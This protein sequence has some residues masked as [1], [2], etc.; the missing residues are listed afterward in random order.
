MSKIIDSSKEF[1]QLNPRLEGLRSTILKELGD[2]ARFKKDYDKAE[3]LYKE[4]LT[5]GDHPWTRFELGNIQM[6]RGYFANG[7]K[8]IFLAL[9][10]RP[11]L[12]LVNR[13]VQKC[14][15]KGYGRARL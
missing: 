11:T 8:N 9:D 12:W 14:N 15:A 1:W 6:N 4:S 2:Q 7:C 13:N 10:M 3:S 5:L